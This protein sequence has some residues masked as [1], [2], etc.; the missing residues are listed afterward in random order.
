MTEALAPGKLVICGEYAVLEGA[1]AIAL[2]VQT[3]ASARVGAAGQCR[4]EVAGHGAWP[5]RWDAR[6]MP[7]WLQQPPPAGQGRVLEAVCATL[8]AEGMVQAGNLSVNLDTRAFEHGTAG[9]SREKLGLGSSAAITVA[10]TAALLT[11]AGS[12]VLDRPRL[13]R[14]A[15]AAHRR[16]QGD[17]GS[18]IDVAAAVHGG[19]VGMSAARDRAGLQGL[20]WPAG[21]CWLAAWSGSG[22]STPDLLARF[23][24]YRLE[25][26]AQS[27]PYMARLGDAAEQT[28]AAW[29][30]GDSGRV[31][32]ALGH[33]Q[34][35][36]RELDAAAGIGIW[37]PAHQRL[38]DMAD[39]AGAM[40]KTSGA[41]GGDFG[42]AFSGS[43]RVMSRLA[44]DYAAAGVLTLT[45][46]SAVPG[47]S[48][49]P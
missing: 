40:Y 33:Y 17:G 41:G 4:L 31:I 13:L 27:A 14:L 34:A 22:A 6:G 47:A 7:C 44:A 43:A 46:T 32:T 39:A 20:A 8:A 25:Q 19:V 35:C 9:G 45:G 29:Q 38:A 36:L 18:G 5:F 28:A 2:A 42:L 24:R 12:A 10:L 49:S 15:T 30:Q 21:L 37:T 23:R 16:L 1:S 48:V 3:S 11:H 26:S